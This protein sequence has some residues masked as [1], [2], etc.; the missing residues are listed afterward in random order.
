MKVPMLKQIYH[1][2]CSKL[3]LFADVALLLLLLLNSLFVL[4]LDVARANT[5][6]TPGKEGKHAQFLSQLKSNVREFTL[7]NGLR[8]ILY[9]RG[10]TPIFNGQLWVKVG[11]INELPG[12]T[13]IAHLLE[14]M[15]FKGTET[16]GTRDYTEEKK[17]LLQIEALVKQHGA[18]DILAQPEYSRILAKLQQLWRS[19]EFS[20]VYERNGAEGLNA[21]T[22]KDYT[23]YTVSLPKVA[24]ELWCFMES[25]RL[26]RPVFRQFYEER[27]V[28]QEERRMS[29]DD[30]PQGLLYEGLLATAYWNHP[31]RLPVIG[32]PSDLTNLTATDIAELHRRYYRP[33]NMVLV[34]VGDLNPA[35]VQPLLERYFG[36]LKAPQEA[37]PLL[38]A[39]EQPQRGER[40]VVIQYDAKP[41][42][43]IA[44]RKPNTM[45]PD[46]APFT[47]LHE[48]LSG[49]RSSLLTKELVIERRVAAT[50]ATSEVPGELYDPLFIIAATP[51]QGVSSEA[52]R[53]D[54]QRLLDKLK[55]RGFS[56]Q[57]LQ[58]AKRRLLVGLL[59]QLDSN[60]GLASFLGRS[61]LL[62]QDW[63]V[64]FDAYDRTLQAQNEDLKRVL[65]S[66]FLRSKRTF[67]KLQKPEG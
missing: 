63:R 53:D 37:L 18:K 26:L 24:F 62:W 16:I 47:L 60:S 64:I 55:N 17:L 40:N 30:D 54:I 66:Y 65:S 3:C 9:S 1:E 38:S 51:L 4:K 27:K 10:E 11:G 5:N 46:D 41:S 32:W 19:D 34:L 8:A 28:V 25:E 13:G 23:F 56:L 12:K 20:R 49:N 42:L 6:D 33:D 35:Q 48:L 22:S 21:G 36:R 57:E 39:V 29:T 50:V 15:A 2:L 52:L 58:A 7:S 45:H 59:E 61:A 43:F 44:Y 31:N 67:A 14:H